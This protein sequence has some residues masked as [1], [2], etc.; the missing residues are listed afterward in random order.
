MKIKFLPILLVSLLVTMSAMTSCLDND[1]EQVTY[2]SETSITSFSLGTLHIKRVG[3]DSKGED[4]TY[5]DTISMAN[6]PFT[7]NQA[8]RT[9]ENKDSLPVGTDISR[10]LT[11][12]QLT[13]II[14]CMVKSIQK[15]LKP[16]ILSGLQAILSTLHLLQQKD[17]LSKFWLI[18]A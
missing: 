1:I 4:S 7:I 12:S 8:M 10:V 3:K 16:K 6:Y 14:F 15:E 5:T 11:K 17:F 13:L 18:V 2:S 9:I